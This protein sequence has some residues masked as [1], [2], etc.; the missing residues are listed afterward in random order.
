MSNSP[1]SPGPDLFFAGGE[2]LDRFGV[3]VRRTDVDLE[4]ATRE[5]FTR[6]SDARA[7]GRDGILRTWGIDTARGE[8]LNDV[9]LDATRNALPTSEAFG[10]PWG[11]VRAARAFGLAT[12]PDGSPA[13]K[14]VEDT[15]PG[16]NTHYNNITISKEPDSLP[17]VFSIF[18][19]PAER[20]GIRIEVTESSAVNGVRVDFANL[21]ELTPGNSST[22]G[23]GWT[24]VGT[25]IEPAANGYVRLSVAVTSNNFDTIRT[26]IYLRDETTNAYQG[27]GESGLFQWGAQ[28]ESGGDLTAYQSTPRDLD[29]KFPALLLEDTRENGWTNSE[30]L[31]LNWI[32]NRASVS[33]DAG[34]APDGEIT[35]DTLV[36]DGQLGSHFI[37]RATPALADNQ[38][39]AVSVYAKA[40]GRPEIRLGLTPKDNSFETAWFDLTVGKGRVGSVSAGASARITELPDGWYRCE[41]VAGNK[42]G[43]TSPQASINMGEGGE[44]PTYQGNGASGVRLWGMQIET[45]K[46]NASSYVPTGGAT[47]TRS[48][49]DFEAPYPHPPQAATYYTKFIES[50]TAAVRFGL[51]SIGNAGRDVPRLEIFQ[52]GNYGV[53]HTTAS[54]AVSSS[55]IAPVADG[56]LIE[57]VGRLFEDG[58]VV[59]T[60]S[61]NGASEISGSRSGGLDFEPAWADQILWMNALGAGFRGFADFIAL[62][63]HRGV[64]SLDFMRAL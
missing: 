32:L 29:R 46:P 56:D 42:T 44:E 53:F 51:L 22:F 16:N 3:W 5:T 11:Q 17:F 23:A 21:R 34:S 54:G 39:T 61:V 7:T 2:C 19:R 33:V 25:D 58:S 4:A 10:V 31:E 13:E 27:D 50:G 47:A 38:D 63:G 30:E 60:I 49:D 59:A 55:A 8:W 52:D 26:F 40:G 15:T 18:V 37:S 14:I 12:G 62:K 6:A 57:F 41:L 43:G 45:D 28:L 1:P 48:R 24:V 9:D 20:N 35:A 64:R 36:E